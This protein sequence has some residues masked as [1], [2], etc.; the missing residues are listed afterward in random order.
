MN[1]KTYQK[2]IEISKDHGN[3]HEYLFRTFNQVDKDMIELAYD[4]QA[5]SYIRSRMRED[6]YYKKLDAELSEIINKY[7]PDSILEAGAGELTTICNIE[8]N[9]KKYAFDLSYSRIEAGV[10]YFGSGCEAFVADMENIPLADNSVDVVYTYHSIESNVGREHIVLSELLR[11]TAKYLI[12]F[13][14]VYELSDNRA[15]SEMRKKGYCTNINYS[16]RNL[17]RKILSIKRLDNIYNE[18]NPTYCI[19]IEKDPNGISA[20]NYQCPIT[21]F[22]ISESPYIYPEINNI[23]VFDPRK[24][25]YQRGEV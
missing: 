2:I 13:E 24:A 21:G 22:P 1:K 20:F 17:D 11:V 3:V 25:I 6:D 15:R 23:R 9:A 4:L 8:T 18:L 14:P 10:D 5:G 19:I 16:V 7:N 12:L